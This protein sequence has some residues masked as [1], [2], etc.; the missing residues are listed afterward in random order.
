MKFSNFA[1]IFM[2][3]ALCL[4]IVVFLNVDITQKVNTENVEY[5]NKLTSAVWDAAKTMKREN[6]ETYGHI[7]HNRNDLNETMDVFYN[8]L[9]YSFNWDTQGRLSEMALY[10]PVVCLIDED[11]YYIS[12]NVVFDETGVVSI[13]DSANERYGLTGLNTWTKTYGGV[14][15]QFYLSDR[16]TVYARDGKEYSGNRYDVYDELCR[17]YPGGYEP[18]YLAFI[19]NDPAYNKEKNELII[20]EINS[21]CEYY[22]N[23][24]NIIGDDYEMKYTFEMPEISG[25]EWMR[26]LEHPTVI[27]FLQGYTSA[28]DNRLLNVYALAGGEITVNYHYFIEAGTNT[29]HC[30]EAEPGVQ[31]HTVRVPVTNVATGETIYTEYVTYTYHGS[32][33][34]A[35]YSSQTECAQQGAYPCECVYNWNL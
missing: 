10:T 13:P 11:G 3:I 26:L 2:G 5:A 31:R 28:A 4:S 9:V 19:V 21:Q 32:P 7:W 16:V 24:H 1:I 30:I 25:E 6:L 27:S 14:I 18:T 35:I 23:N 34:T 20:R 8:S 12:H 15:L 22:I 33:I 17:A 29:Y